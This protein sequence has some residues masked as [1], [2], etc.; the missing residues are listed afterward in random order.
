MDNLIA[1]RIDIDDCMNDMAKV[2]QYFEDL[3]NLFSSLKT[4]ISD[5]SKWS[6]E[7]QEKAE[8]I[9][10]LISKYEKELRSIYENMKKEI[11]V[12]R[13]TAEDFTANSNGISELRAW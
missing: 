9:Q 1:V 13:D 7:A 11:V 6:G 5:T 3:E 2:I 8:S 4:K 12:L 10:Q